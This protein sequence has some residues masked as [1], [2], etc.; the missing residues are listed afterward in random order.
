MSYDAYYPPQFK[1]YL[2]YYHEND[3]KR[4]YDV[5]MIYEM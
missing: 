4:D 3:D 1:I 5:E 2:Y